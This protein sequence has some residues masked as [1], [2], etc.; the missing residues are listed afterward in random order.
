MALVVVTRVVMLLTI[1]GSTDID[2]TSESFFCQP[3]NSAHRA[4]HIDQMYQ[5]DQIYRTE[6]GDQ[7]DQIPTPCS[8]CFRGLYVVMMCM[9]I[10][11]AACRVGAA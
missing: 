11:C 9:V 5:I 2:Q 8:R 4:K 3:L 7:I 6:Q 1:F 10:A